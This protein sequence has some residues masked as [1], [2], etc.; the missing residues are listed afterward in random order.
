VPATFPTGPF[1]RVKLHVELACPSG[2]C[3]AW[4]RRASLSVLD[5]SGATPIALEFARFVTPYGV[6]G[7]WDLDVTDL[8]PLFTG[9]RTVRGFI[10]T[11]VGPGSSFGGGW[12]LTATLSF[13]RGTPDHLPIAIAPLGW[14][15]AVYGDPDRTIASQLVPRAVTAPAG[16]VSSQLYVLTT[17]HGQGNVENCAEFCERM[18][19]VRVDTT[20]HAWSVWRGDCGDNPITNQRGTWRYSRAGWCPGDMVQPYVEPLGNAFAPG[21]THTVSYDVES[22][23]NT[24]RPTASPCVGCTLGG[25]CPYNDGSHTEPF[26]NVTGYVIFFGS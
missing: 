4:D 25:D 10:D 21:A 7:S 17:G 5:S 2:G 12:S 6:G 13:E 26:Y 20:P 8:Q 3:D 15:N 23:V 18:H 9:S 19:T 14:Q 16:T 22:Y 1:R 24:C 11:W